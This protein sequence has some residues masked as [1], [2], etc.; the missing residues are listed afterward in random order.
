MATDLTKLGSGL[1]TGLRLTSTDAFA[2]IEKDAAE[3]TVGGA[4]DGSLYASFSG[5]LGRYKVGTEGADLSD[6]E[7]F[8]LNIESFESG[9]IC[10]KSG[11]PIAKRMSS[12]YSGTVADPDMTE[13]GPFKEGEGWS[14]IKALVAYSCDR[15][16]A[17]YF[18]TSSKS[19][20]SEFSKLQLAAVTRYRSG[21]PFWP[22]FRFTREKFTSRGNTNYKPTF[23]VVG[24]LTTAAMKHLSA[25]QDV[26]VEDLIEE[27]AHGQWSDFKSEA[28][29]A[30]TGAD[31]SAETVEAEVVEE[32]ATPPENSANVRRRAR[33][34]TQ[35]S[36][37]TPTARRRL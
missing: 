32:E 19:G 12:I 29:E 30:A 17:L 18:S 9:W 25:S 34:E 11:S 28:V 35:T 33:I 14:R 4:P 22:V 21:Q 3:T 5:K 31:T 13:H 1:G 24:W 16:V 2:A 37:Q 7:L 23:T 15:D 20:L 10:W 27:V 36:A 6:A 26:Y 8:I